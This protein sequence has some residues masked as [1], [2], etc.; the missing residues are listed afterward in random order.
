[1]RTRFEL[2]YLP[3]DF[4]QATDLA[5]SNPE[6]VKELQDLFW[7]EA[8]KY[9]IKPLLAGFATFFGI[10]PP[11]GTQTTYTYY[12]DVQNV[13]PGT[14][15]RV[16]N[17]SYT[18]SADLHIPDGGAEGVIV[19]EANHLGGFALFVQDG[20]LKHTY[21][22]LGVFEY[23]Q[24]SEGELPTGDVN[25]QM[26]FVADEAKPATPGQ[27]TLYV[28]GKPTGSGRLDHTVPFIFSGYSGLDVG[29]DNGLVVDRSYA[30][31]A[32]FTF[33]GTVKKVVFDVAPHPDGK[34]E[35]ALHEHAEQAHAA[36]G[37]NA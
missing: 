27:V 11:L 34:D 35:L 17:H 16:Y 23:H 14:I 33:T 29:R 1:M 3:D 25:V 4:S 32:P 10:L 9:N 8:E 6:K 18:I 22:F 5:A 13:A 19:A 26:T 15:P 21:A 37:I 31:K 2:Y 7:E 36:R 12:G 20:K 28:N 30:D 24:E